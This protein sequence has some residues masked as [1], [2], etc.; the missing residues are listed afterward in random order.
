[1][2]W[3]V[4]VVLPFY[5]CSMHHF[6]P[7]L[8]VPKD[9]QATPWE[10]TAWKDKVENLC[11]GAHSLEFLGSTGKP[12]GGKS[13]TLVSLQKELSCCDNK[14]FL[15][16]EVGKSEVV[17]QWVHSAHS[18]ECRVLQRHPVPFKAKTVQPTGSVQPSQQHQLYRLVHH[19]PVFPQGMGSNK[20]Q[21]C[22]ISKV[23]LP[24]SF[25]GFFSRRMDSLKG[26][27]MLLKPPCLA[28]STHSFWQ[29]LVLCTLC[30]YYA[31]LSPHFP[32][33]SWSWT[34][35]ARC[36][37]WGWVT[38]W[39]HSWGMQVFGTPLERPCWKISRVYCTKHK[40]TTPRVWKRANSFQDYR[41]KKLKSDSNSSLNREK[42]KKERERDMRGS[43]SMHASLD[44]FS[45]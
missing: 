16:T 34:T 36:F 6:F 18:R 31:M 32:W 17:V 45:L 12:G 41:I 27:N 26:V 42:K 10:P 14:G 21:G 22:S 43:S 23:T 40:P 29:R 2:V 9:P 15:Q 30:V 44:V 19:S 4:T 13:Q 37:W 38:W 35:E 24:L 1:M 8:R 20:V 5:S 7:I 11:F 39:P 3:V 25:W 33:K 28:L